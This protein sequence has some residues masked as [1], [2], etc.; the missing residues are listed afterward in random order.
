VSRGAAALDTVPAQA[1]HELSVKVRCP[2]TLARCVAGSVLATCTRVR[3]GS[4][5]RRTGTGSSLVHGE[6]AAAF[7]IDFTGLPL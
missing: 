6:A 3:G 4:L 5:V 7:L 1:G 2:V